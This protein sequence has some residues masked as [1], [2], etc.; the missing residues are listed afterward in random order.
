MAILSNYGVSIYLGDG[1]G[2]QDFGFENV[3]FVEY[4]CDTTLSCHPELLY[5]LDT[6]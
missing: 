6:T 5:N 3:L 1:I 4:C 2:N